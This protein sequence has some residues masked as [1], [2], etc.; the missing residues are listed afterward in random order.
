MRTDNR[1]L[2]QIIERAEQDIYLLG[3]TFWG[4]QNSVGGDTLVCHA[5][6][7]RFANCRHADPDV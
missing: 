3:Q 4:R 7:A 6:W 1:A 5:V 2:N